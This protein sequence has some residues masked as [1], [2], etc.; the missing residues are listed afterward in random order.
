MSVYHEKQQS[1]C[2]GR[3]AINNLLQTPA[4]TDVE[5]AEIAMGLYE[6]E[7]T[8]RLQNCDGM[9]DPSFI[10]FVGAGNPYVDDSGNFSVE[11]IERALES[12]GVTL[13]R[14]RTIESL[15]NV[16]S[17]QAYLLNRSDHWM[18]IRRIADAQ[19]V[20]HW[21]DLN[22]ILTAPEHISDFYLSAVLAQHK[23]DG[24]AY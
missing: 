8:L 2:C 13:T 18:A 21:I 12:H 16:E 24:C 20:G 15:E 5:L 9:G 11:V 19:G 7:K 6:T 4:W 1:A 17:F 10:E 14:A 22:S 3:H 23:K